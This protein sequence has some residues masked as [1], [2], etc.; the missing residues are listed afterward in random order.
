MFQPGSA[1]TTDPAIAS[2]FA[3]RGMIHTSGRIPFGGKWSVLGG[4]ELNAFGSPDG[5]W[6]AVELPSAGLQNYLPWTLTRTIPGL[7]LPSVAARRKDVEGLGRTQGHPP[8]AVQGDPLQ[9]ESIDFDDR[10]DVWSVDRRAGAM[11]ID[12]GMMQ[13]LLDCDRVSFE[14]HGDKLS[15]V[16]RLAGADSGAATQLEL[17]F[18]FCQGFVARVPDVVRSEFAAAR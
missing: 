3:Q 7:N 6:F 16:I 15:A 12:Q 9:F 5:L 2:V 8:L 13:W 17:L 4:I 11:L 14:V 1:G 18:G 10:F